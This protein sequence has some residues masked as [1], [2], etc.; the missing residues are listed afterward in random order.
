MNTRM[1]PAVDRF[2]TALPGRPAT[3]RREPD[4]TRHVMNAR[5]RKVR[6]DEDGRPPVGD[7]LHLAVQRRERFELPLEIC[8]RDG[9]RLRRRL[10]RF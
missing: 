5:Q 4:L 2:R 6:R 7:G 3:P 1:A 9:E 8:P 10:D